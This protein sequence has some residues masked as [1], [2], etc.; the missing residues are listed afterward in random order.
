MP[1]AIL[2]VGG[3]KASLRRFL[4]QTSLKPHRVYL[5]GEPTS[6]GARH[7]SKNSYFLVVASKAGGDDFP[8][9]VRDV[10]RFVKVNLK[11][12]QA[13]PSHRLHAVVDFGV[14]DTRTRKHPLLSWRL[15]VPLHSL[16]SKAGLEAEISIY[17]A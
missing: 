10:A 1:G 5:R 16:L 17:D 14:Y 8:K 4:A 7:V 6:H 2:R 13:M 15:P 12:L 9:Q 11:D 3:S